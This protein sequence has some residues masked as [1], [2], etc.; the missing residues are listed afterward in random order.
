MS[1]LGKNKMKDKYISFNG[2][3]YALN[4]EKLKEVCLTSSGE[5]DGRESEVT[6]VYEPDGSGDFNVASRVE[7][8]TKSGKILQNDMIVYDIVK[9]LILGLLEN[10]KTEDEF[11]FDFSTAFAV[12][13]LLNWGILEEKNE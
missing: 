1:L 10:N 12:N 2:K 5:Y 7:H 11:I 8:E 6:L 4:L 9:L 3:K 13:T